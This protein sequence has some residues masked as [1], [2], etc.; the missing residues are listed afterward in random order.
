MYLNVIYN[1]V[2]QW[3]QCCGAVSK[4]AACKHQFLSW[5]EKVPHLTQLNLG[6]QAKMA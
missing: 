5:N 4:A 6:K 1:L 3:S 2:L